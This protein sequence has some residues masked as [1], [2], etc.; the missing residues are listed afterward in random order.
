VKALLEKAAHGVL[1]SVV[2]A[3][4][5]FGTGGIVAPIAL[6]KIGA[7]T[8]AAYMLKPARPGKVAK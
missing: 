5:L 4:A 6:A 3:A 7:A 8:F 2:T 1:L